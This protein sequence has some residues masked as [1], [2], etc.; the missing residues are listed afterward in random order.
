MEA[1]VTRKIPGKPD[2]VAMSPEQGLSVEELI[3]AYTKNVAWSLH[4]EDE[5]GSIEPGKWADMIVLNHNLLEI[6]ETDL[7]KTEVQKTI[8][9]GDIVY[10]IE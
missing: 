7:H 3:V 8:F 5:T 2:S 4:I 1:A 9:K 6:P 10:E